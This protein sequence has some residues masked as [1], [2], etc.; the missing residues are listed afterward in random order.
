MKRYNEIAGLVK[1]DRNIHKKVQIECKD[2]MY[3]KIYDDKEEKQNTVPLVILSDVHETLGN[4]Y[5][6]YK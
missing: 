4:T 3:Q 1:S 2:F 5:V 6:P